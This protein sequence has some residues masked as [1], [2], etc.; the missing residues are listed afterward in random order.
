[1]NSKKRRRGKHKSGLTQLRAIKSKISQRSWRHPERT[2]HH[3]VIGCSIPTAI[4]EAF[5]KECVAQQN[6]MRD[7]LIKLM[8]YYVWNQ[9]CRMP[10]PPRYK[11]IQKLL[12][13][14]IPETTHL[15]FKAMCITQGESIGFAF[16]NLMRYYASNHGVAEE[17]PLPPTRFFRNDPKRDERRRT[18]EYARKN[19]AK[20]TRASLN[21]GLDPD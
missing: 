11:S 18:I 5:R 3:K 20:T 7:A 6:T 15:G 14:C 19:R 2:R 8:R 17:A 1:M 9:G 4:K 21:R 10:R 12:V 16:A 13:M